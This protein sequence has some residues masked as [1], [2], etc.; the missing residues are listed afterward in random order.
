MATRQRLET[1]GFGGEAPI[2]LLSRLAERLRE[3][4]EIEADLTTFRL[5]ESLRPQLDA[6]IGRA[7]A[8][9]TFYA[10]R[11]SGAIGGTR[12]GVLREAPYPESDALT[13]DARAIAAEVRAPYAAMPAPSALGLVDRHF[14]DEAEAGAAIRDVVARLMRTMRDAG[15]AGHVLLTP[16]PGDEE[17]ADLASPFTFFYCPEI[18]PGAL[19]VLLD[20]QRAFALPGRRVAELADLVDQFGRRTVYLVDPTENEVAAGLEVLDPDHLRI[21]GFCPGECDPYWQ[22]LAAL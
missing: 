14:G 12:D 10:G 8:G 22:R 15:V 17:L 9:G 4:P 16:S 13:M 19:E 21:G 11:W 5:L 2:P 1:R 6:G 3:R 7:A 20:H 18:D